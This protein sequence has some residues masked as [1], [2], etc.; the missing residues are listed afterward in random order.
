MRYAL[1]DGEEMGFAPIVPSKKFT[2]RQE[3][4]NKDEDEGS[5]ATGG[6]ATGVGWFC[7]CCSVL[8]DSPKK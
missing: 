5:I 1:L 6:G 7:L 2:Y 3:G 8:A 4:G